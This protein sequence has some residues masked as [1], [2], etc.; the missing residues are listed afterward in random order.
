MLRDDAEI[1][2]FA[3]AGR[4]RVHQASAPPVP[5]QASEVSVLLVD[6]DPASREVV[7]RY[8]D[9]A[10][11]RTVEAEGGRQALAAL[12][13]GAVG[14]FVVTD[15]QMAAGSGGWLLAQLAYEYPGLL[16]RT[17][18]V[19]GDADSAAAAHIAARWRCP[20]LA[21]PFTAAQ[22]M[23]TLVRLSARGAEVA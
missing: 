18:V 9:R 2:R 10:S 13:A 1:E 7:R 17:A 3:D 21:K 15:L 16:P 8:L 20:M 23:N 4:H 14:H 5:A 12:R 19:S 22:L 6:D 11:Y